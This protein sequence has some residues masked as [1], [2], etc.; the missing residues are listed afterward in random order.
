[1]TV[2]D[3]KRTFRAVGTK[4]DVGRKGDGPLSEMSAQEQK[5]AS[6]QLVAAFDWPQLGEV[7]ITLLGRF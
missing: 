7:E 3:P 5:S 1:M 6:T 2:L 4:S